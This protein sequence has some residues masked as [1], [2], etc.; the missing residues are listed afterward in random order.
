MIVDFHTHIF[1]PEMIA[2]REA[3]AARD[4]TFAEMYRDRRARM[5]TA[6]DL[7]RSMDAAGI[8]VSVALGF[9]WSD[10]EDCRRHND[11]LLEEAARSR[12]RILA[13]CCLAPE[14]DGPTV[15]AEVRRVA[16]GGARGLGELRSTCG[17]RS[18]EGAD[19][20][21]STGLVPLFH[22]SEPVGHHYPGKSGVP[23][24]AMVEAASSLPAPLVAAHW[25]GGLPF[26]TLMPEVRV[27]LEGAYFDTAASRFL[28]AADVYR[29]VI[30]LVGADRVLFGSDFP[31]VAQEAARREAESAGLPAS[32]LALVLGGNAARLLGLT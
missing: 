13:F 20:L 15:A 27:A 30:D 17:L 8:D 3:L 6:Q 2:S 7:L 10:M 1:P 31:L 23:L 28:Y 11:Y 22:V 12:G 21:G 18:P 24:D 26:F 9:A 29:R 5:A 4:V 14:A 25:G 32:G 16:A 19:A